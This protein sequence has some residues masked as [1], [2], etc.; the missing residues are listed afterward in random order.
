[1]DIVALSHEWQD[2]KSW[3][4]FCSEPR[5][6]QNLLLGHSH[7]APGHRKKMQK[8]SNMTC[9]WTNLMKGRL[10]GG[11]MKLKLACFLSYRK[12]AGSKERPDTEYLEGFCLCLAGRQILDP[13]PAWLDQAEPPGWL[14]VTGRESRF[15]QKVLGLL[16]GWLLLHV[17][18]SVEECSYLYA[19]WQRSNRNIK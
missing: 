7:G 14:D 9:Q 17:S 18:G 19:K 2:P 12:E 13:V 11:I 16:D 1:M 10:A 15:G 8:W 5:C 4:H 3:P 6:V